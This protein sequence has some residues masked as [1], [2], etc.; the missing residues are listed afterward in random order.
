[1][2]IQLSRCL[3]DFVEQQVASRGYKSAA[4]YL[5]EPIEA[6]RRQITRQQIESEIINGI[7]S[8]PSTPLTQ[9]EWDSIREEVVSRHRARMQKEST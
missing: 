6:D 8:G 1:M 7:Q 2:Q 9:E 4:D 3:F 5:A